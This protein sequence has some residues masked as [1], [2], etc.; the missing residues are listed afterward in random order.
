MPA[1]GRRR[2]PSLSTL[3]LGAACGVLLAAPAR[4]DLNHFTCY[5]VRKAPF[6][7]VNVDLENP[8]GFTMADIKKPKRLCTPTNKNDEDPTAPGDAE[9]LVGYRMRQT[10]PRRFEKELGLTVTNQFGTLLVDAVNVDLLMVPSAKS[11]IAPPQ[12]LPNPPGIDHYECYRVRRAQQQVDG[13]AIEDQFGT[14]TLDV[15]R[16]RSVCIATDLEGYGI[17]EPEA[18]LA[19]YK[20]RTTKRTPRFPGRDLVFVKNVFGNSQGLD[21]F[22]ITR[23]T[24]LCLPSTIT[25]CFTT[26]ILGPCP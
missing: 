25:R 17:A 13:I 1:H 7:T 16:P 24:E 14:L 21:F 23:P 4:A 26:P 18:H 2:S 15:K 5:E 20:V 19:C 8:F 10:E 11:E 22:T 3:I 12:P 6:Q 9:H